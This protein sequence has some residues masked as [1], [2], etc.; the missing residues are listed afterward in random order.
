MWQLK[1]VSVQVLSKSVATDLISKEIILSLQQE[2]VGIFDGWEENLKQLLMKFL[3]GEDFVKD[4]DII[5]LKKLS[6]YVTY[7]DFPYK[8]SICKGDILESFAKMQMSNLPTETVK[9]MLKMC[10]VHC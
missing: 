4:E 6:T 9:K 10:D 1:L 5:R 3:S 7:Y 2:V 8:H